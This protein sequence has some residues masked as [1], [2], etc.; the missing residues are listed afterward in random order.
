MDASDSGSDEETAPA[1]PAATISASRHSEPA[2]AVEVQGRSALMHSGVDTCGRW[3]H[4]CLWTSQCALV[5]FGVPA[6]ALGSVALAVACL[7]GDSGVLPPPADLLGSWGAFQPQFPPTTM[8]P[9]LWSAVEE[10]QAWGWRWVA[11]PAAAAWVLWVAGLATH[12]LVAARD[13]AWQAQ[14]ASYTQPLPLPPPGWVNPWQGQLASVMGVPTRLLPRKAAAAVAT[15]STTTTLASAEQVFRHQT[16]GLQDL[17]VDVAHRLWRHLSRLSQ[18]PWLRRGRSLRQDLLTCSVDEDTANALRWRGMVCLALAGPLL[19]LLLLTVKLEAATWHGLSPAAAAA[20]GPA[21]AASTAGWVAPGGQPCSSIVGG[22]ALCQVLQWL[23]PLN[24]GST[25]L[26]RALTQG[27]EPALAALATPGGPTLPWLRWPFVALPLIVA[28]GVLWLLAV[29]SVLLC[30]RGM[31]PRAP[32]LAS[33]GDAGAVL[34]ADGVTQ[35]YCPGEGSAVRAVVPGS[36]E[37]AGEAGGGSGEGAALQRGGVAGLLALAAV[38]VPA[39]AALVLGALWLDMQE[40]GLLV[41]AGRV[42]TRT[43][44]GRADVAFSPTAAQDMQVL[45]LALPILCGVW[46]CVVAAAGSLWLSSAPW[47]DVS[48]EAMAELTTLTEGLTDAQVAAV[49]RRQAAAPAPPRVPAKVDAVPVQDAW[50][51]DVGVRGVYLDGWRWKVLKLGLPPPL[52]GA[53]VTLLLVWGRAEGVLMAD[54]QQAAADSTAGEGEVTTVGVWWQV[55][56]PLLLGCAIALM[57]CGLSAWDTWELNGMFKTGRGVWRH[58]AG[59][60]RLATEAAVVPK[61]PPFKH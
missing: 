13:T 31:S 16:T 41:E 25:L 9:P 48:E 37:G 32:G 46:A 8:E 56:L 57:A 22:T 58:V 26:P 24:S 43:R 42:L 23:G 54:R 7:A 50:A 18:A 20:L 21:A 33:A 34:A 6:L 5:S 15:S 3:L 27:A 38:G 44:A 49:G 4:V 45:P 17:P 55:F 29:E 39:T 14:S 28:V 60:D 36:G 19:F 35:V 59:A 1:P 61:R 40:A 47:G 11:F 53:A 10:G 52:L 2:Q 12:A 51:W 30:W